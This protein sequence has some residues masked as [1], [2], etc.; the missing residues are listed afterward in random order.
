M[1]GRATILAI[2][3]CLVLAV[4]CAALWVRSYRKTDGMYFLLDRKSALVVA[5]FSSGGS[6]RFW[7]SSRGY[8]PVTIFEW[9]SNP[10]RPNIL[11]SEGEIGRWG[12]AYGRPRRYSYRW[13][14]APFAAMVAAPLMIAG[15]LLHHYRR[16]R[17]R[18]AVAA[19]HCPGCGYD[20]RAS[21]GRCPECG[22][23]AAAV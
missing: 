2:S 6:T 7:W 15:L 17:K 1:L 13:V 23:P 20:L 21:P 19:G 10:Y 4:L 14:R 9:Q 16:R 22:R 18:R 11:V 5:L 3:V 12:F 8:A